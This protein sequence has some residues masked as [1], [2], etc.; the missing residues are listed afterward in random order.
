MPRRIGANVPVVPFDV[1]PHD[2][3]EPVVIGGLQTSI[4][5]RRSARA[6]RI[7][8]R[9]DPQ[10]GRIV[11][12]LPPRGSRKAGLALLRGHEIWV[13]ERLAALPAPV[14]IAD[15]NEI[16]IFGRPHRIIHDPSLRGGAIIER[17]A[18]RIGGHPEFLARRVRDALHDLALRE[19]SAQARDKAAHVGVRPAAIRVKDTRT[20]WGSCAANGTLMFSWRLIMAPSFVQDYVVAHEAAHLRHM[21]HGPDFWRLAEMLTPH[22]VAATSWLAAEGP[23]LLRIS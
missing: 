3:A 10:G 17:A 13:A 20:R 7:A 2:G 9:I 22:R 19:L 21:N 18:I 14:I 11:I 16:P 1:E 23:G 4:L 15:G 6:R 8:L 12:T 5:W